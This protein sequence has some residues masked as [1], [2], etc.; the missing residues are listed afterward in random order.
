MTA[1]VNHWATAEHAGVYLARGDAYPPQRGHGEAVLV[2]ELPERVDRVLDLGCGDGRLLAVVLEARPAATGVAVDFSDTMLAAAQERFADRPG[3]DVVA[4]DLAQPLPATIEGP[5][6]VVVSSFAIHHLE[7]RRKHAL[8]GEVRD[9]LR[10]GGLF[11]NLE[12]VSSASPRLRERFW[13]EMGQD[14]AQEDPA[15]RLAPVE[16]QLRWLRDL[17]YVDV[18]CLWRWRELALLV[19]STIL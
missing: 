11:A 12:H 13:Q 3:L 9:R 8:F 19:G 14:P 2:A 7:H 6:D 4:H 18:D 15:N 17:G 1:T 5:F 10:P 16:N